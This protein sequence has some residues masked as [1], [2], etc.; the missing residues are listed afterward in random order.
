MRKVTAAQSI[1]GVECVGGTCG[2]YYYYCD[3]FLR[4]LGLHTEN[5]A[6]SDWKLMDMVAPIT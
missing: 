1:S 6:R 5:R 4:T 3:I 2:C